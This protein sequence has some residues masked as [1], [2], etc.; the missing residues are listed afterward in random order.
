ML[1]ALKFVQGAV[2][3]KDFVPALTH[4]HIKAGRIKGYN[5]RIALSSPIPLD[6]DV[7]PKATSLIKAIQT[8]R[9]TVQINL[10]STGKL[11]I[12]SGKFKALVD[13]IN[14]LSLYP[15][16]EPEGE[17]VLLPS[18]FLTTLKTLYP[19]IAEDASRPWA[20]GILFRGQSAYATNNVILVEYW[21]GASFEVPVNIPKEAISEILR[22]NENPERMLMTKSN[23]TFY[24]SGDRWLRTQL[25]DLNWPNVE[26]L[27]DTEANCTAIPEGLFPALKDLLPFSDEFESVYFKDS[28]I[29]TS[30]GED[31]KATIEIDGLPSIGAYNIK[32]LMNLEGVA[33]T[34]D[35]SMYPG[36]CT[37]YG[38]NIRGVII[39]VTG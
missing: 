21:V 5:G 4:F 20:R 10:T 24:F 32:Q 28:C 39:G 37:F 3:K 17:E 11:S 38:D 33:E 2:A 19:F 22:I 18:N 16:V 1:E 26:P 34:M 31:S 12:R 29:A 8:C 23:V 25:Y 15:E 36:A 6:L 14:N 35:F 9:D 27:L 13:C 30:R 7:I